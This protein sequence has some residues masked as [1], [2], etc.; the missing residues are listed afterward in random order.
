MSSN[1]I[2]VGPASEGKY[3]RL[4]VQV[5]PASGLP[6]TGSGGGGTSD[7]AIVTNLEEIKAEIID[8][9][10][11]PITDARRDVYD[12]SQ[13][14]P[15]SWLILPPNPDRKKVR[16]INNIG[17]GLSSPPTGTAY[18]FVGHNF[19]PDRTLFDHVISPGDSVLV[20]APSL[21]IFVFAESDS[22]FF[23]V[24]SITEYF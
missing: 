10:P 22:P 8:R 24:F 14:G 5:D 15:G 12:A 16:I 18:L 6:V 21:E 17:D 23:G 3:A 11:R 19:K 9:I 1:S 2:Q 7:P 4:T 20:D 13:Y